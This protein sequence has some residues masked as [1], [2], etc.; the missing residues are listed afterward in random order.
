MDCFAASSPYSFD[1]L[2]NRR[3]DLIS[4]LPTELSVYIFQFL[5]LPAM[6][7]TMQVQRSWYWLYKSDKRLRT[8]FKRRMQERQQAR[9]RL[10]RKFRAKN[11][12][13]SARPQHKRKQATFTAKCSAQEGIK[14]FRVWRF[15]SN[16]VQLLTKN[17]Y[18]ILKNI[19][20]AL[21]TALTTFINLK[22]YTLYLPILNKRLT[23]TKTWLLLLL[24]SEWPF[25]QWHKQYTSHIGGNAF[26]AL[27]TSF[28][29]SLYLRFIPHHRGITKM[30]S[31]HNAAFCRFAS[32]QCTTRT[33]YI[34]D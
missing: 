26:Y 10:I 6:I 32:V 2:A 20:F 12:P 4:A 5:D 28:L 22:N 13:L 18:N 29:F 21:H 11:G 19:L 34:W 27:R 3:F 33:S 23:H 16:L 24:N 25:N 31:T 7:A 9:K 15:Q 1:F 30:P 17:Y 14:C 8:T